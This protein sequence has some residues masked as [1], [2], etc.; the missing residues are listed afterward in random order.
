M[1]PQSISSNSLICASASFPSNY[2]TN[3]VIPFKVTTFSLWFEQNNWTLLP[4]INLT[5]YNEPIITDIKPKYGIETEETTITLQGLF[6]FNLIYRCLLLPINSSIIATKN[7]GQIQ[8]V[9][10]P[11][12]SNITEV[13]ELH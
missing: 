2:V 13:Y 8:C 6:D 3:N 4:T 11:K 5:Y 12:N 7:Y 9:I 1:V 10:P